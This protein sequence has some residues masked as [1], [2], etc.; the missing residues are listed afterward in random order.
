MDEKKIFKEQLELIVSD[1]KFDYVFEVDDYVKLVDKVIDIVN[2]LCI[3]M[4]SLF[5][6]QFCSRMVRQ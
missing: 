3:G 2:K 5:W 1:F 4:F 6:I